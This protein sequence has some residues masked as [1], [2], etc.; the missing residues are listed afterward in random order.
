MVYFAIT[1]STDF[2]KAV[3]I[4]IEY[5]HRNWIIER[6]NIYIYMYYIFINI[7]KDFIQNHLFT[8]Y[9]K[10]IFIFNCIFVNNR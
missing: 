9:S 5:S 2:Y 1:L 4:A 6:K 10:T 3:D 8:K 7:S